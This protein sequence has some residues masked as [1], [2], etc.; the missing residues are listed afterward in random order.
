MNKFIY[1][2]AA[3]A[4]LCTGNV[5]AQEAALITPNADS[6]FDCV[7]EN[8]RQNRTLDFEGN[9]MTQE[10]RLHQRNIVRSR[11]LPQGFD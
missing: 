2:L 6:A 7:Q 5:F 9:V 1:P 4:A 8:T 10:Y 3:A 11:S